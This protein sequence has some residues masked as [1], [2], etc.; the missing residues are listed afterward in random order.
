MQMSIDQAL[1]LAEDGMDEMLDR[2]FGRVREQ[3]R[4]AGYPAVDIARLLVAQKA[5]WLAE[6]NNSWPK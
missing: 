4:E 2:E 6:K 3:L 5:A 1:A